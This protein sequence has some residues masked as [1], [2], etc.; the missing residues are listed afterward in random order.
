VAW[1]HYLAQGPNSISPIDS[2][3]DSIIGEIASYG[4]LWILTPAADRRQ[5][6]GRAPL[7]QLCRHHVGAGADPSGNHPRAA[8]T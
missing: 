5:R 6:S 7:V 3:T 4:L 2:A 1:L 8:P